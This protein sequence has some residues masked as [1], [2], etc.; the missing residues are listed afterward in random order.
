LGKKI[1]RRWIWEDLETLIGRIQRIGF[2]GTYSQGGFGKRGRIRL[3]L[4]NYPLEEMGASL[5]THNY[6]NRGFKGGIRNFLLDHF[7]TRKFI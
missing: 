3:N 2:G 1:G 7:F 4:F 6:F 5:L